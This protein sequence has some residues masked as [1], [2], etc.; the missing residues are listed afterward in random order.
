MNQEWKRRREKETRSK[1]RES[2]AQ[3]KK[4]SNGAPIRAII[5]DEA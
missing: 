3:E 4:I 2:K 5:A 1:E